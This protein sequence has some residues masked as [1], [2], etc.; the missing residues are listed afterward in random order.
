VVTVSDD[1]E[2]I[3][4]RVD[5]DTKRQLSG[6]HNNMS[7]IMRDLAEKYSRTGD[8]LEAAL[9]VEREQNEDRLRELKR[10]KSDIQSE[11]DKVERELTRI[12]R[13]LEQ[14][15]ENTTE[16]AMELAEQ[17][18]SGLFPMDNLDADNPA[19]KNKA[20]KAGLDVSEFIFEVRGELE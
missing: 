4:F 2:K 8:T 14:R 13:R 16:E 15:R 17:I 11:I 6:G 10:D 3:T 7:G 9:L 12:D 20:Q 18:D 19:V 1:T 5:S